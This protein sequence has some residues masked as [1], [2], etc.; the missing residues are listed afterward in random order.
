[1][2]GSIMSVVRLLLKAD[3]QGQNVR[4]LK[5]FGTEGYVDIVPNKGYNHLA[6]FSPLDS[7]VPV[8]LTDGEWEVTSIAGV[9]A[10]KNLV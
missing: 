4:P 8:W 5:G 1:M 9:D 7:S 10:A 2:G 6:L 3:R